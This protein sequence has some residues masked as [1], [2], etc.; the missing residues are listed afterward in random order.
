M[1]VV[2]S[3]YGSRGDLEPLAALAVKLIGLGHEAVV[4]TPPDDDFVSLLERVGVPLVP[5]GQPVKEMIAEVSRKQGPNVGRRLPLEELQFRARRMVAT[6]YEAVMAAAGADGDVV[7]GTGL[8]PAACG[9]RSAADQLG[10]GW[11]SVRF[12]PTTLPTGA[13]RPYPYPGRPL[14]EGETDN[15]QL[16]EY[17]RQTMKV[18]FGGVFDEHRATVGLPMVDDVRA[19]VFTDRPWLAADPVI[20]PWPG[21]SDLDVVQTGAWILP[22]DR[23]LP[24]GLVEFLDAG[25]PPVYVG[26][27]SMGLQ[28]NLTGAGRDA[29]EAAR[30]HGRRVVLGS[31]WAALELH[32]DQDDCFAVG[33]VNQQTLFARCAAIVHH[34]G[35]GTT[36]TATRAGRPQVIVPQVV[37]QPYFAGRVAELGIGV[38]HEGSVP[39]LESLTTALRTV[40]SPEL[41]A[42]AREV[43]G[44]V[45]EQGTSVAAGLLSAL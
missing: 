14:P 2:L 13:H 1:R 26:F 37:D 20:A 22:D 24:P 12:Q 4:C 40:L 27:G 28:Q 35:A 3:T 31:G 10:I 5:A 44:S 30:S 21:D 7:V 16:W 45:S 9:A 34:G 36:T 25:E 17:D 29:I 39:T 23:P 38:A 18:V 8:M 33:E 42:R 41:S 32:D 6:Q 11:V 43:A 19:Y 15:H